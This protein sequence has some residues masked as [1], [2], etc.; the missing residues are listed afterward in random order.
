[1]IESRRILYLTDSTEHGGA[2]DYLKGLAAQF[3]RKGYSVRVLLPEAPGMIRLVSQIREQGVETEPLPLIP[4]LPGAVRKTRKAVIVNVL[5]FC[6]YFHRARPHLI[7]FVVSWPTRDNWCGMVAALL[8]RIPY[9]VDFQ[10][11]PPSIL[12]PPTDRGL[13]KRLGAIL[14]FVFNRADRLICVSRGNRSRLAQ[15]FGIREERI[16]V[17][18]HGIDTEYYQNPDSA[19]SWQLRKEFGLSRDRIVITTV[20]RLNVQKGHVHLIDAAK[21]VSAAN[22]KV[23]FLLVGDGELR[24]ELELAVEKAGLSDKFIFAGYRKDIPEILALTDIFLLPTLFEGLPHSVLEAMA[25]G[26]CVVASRVDGVVEVVTEGETGILVDAGNT[27]QFVEALNSLVSN[28]DMRKE[29]GRNGKMRASG[30]FG[31]NHMLEKIE[32]IYATVLAA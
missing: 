30:S 1:M 14:R 27:N 29:L 26:C 8:L 24:E 15:L 11:V 2:E 13:L 10:L 25:A 22:P 9:V 6:R 12:C 32:L 16:D 17:V 19:R 4:L 28:Q 7:H 20:A 31:L 5:A 23:V 18:Y 21:S 3:N